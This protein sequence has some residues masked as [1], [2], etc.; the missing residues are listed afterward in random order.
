MHSRI[1]ERE[2]G[3]HVYGVYRF[4]VPRPDYGT[5]WFGARRGI[6]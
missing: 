1:E 2:E 3:D 5:V 6:F 4:P